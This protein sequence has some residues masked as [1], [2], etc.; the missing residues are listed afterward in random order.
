[1]ISAVMICVWYSIDQPI[2]QSIHRSVHCSV[3]CPVHCLVHCSIRF[4]VPC[5][6]SAFLAVNDAVRLDRFV[7]G[8]WIAVGFSDTQVLAELHRDWWW[9]D[10][11]AR[12]IGWGGVQRHHIYFFADVYFLDFLEA[13]SLLH[14]QQQ[15]QVKISYF[16]VLQDYIRLSQSPSNVFMSFELLD[17]FIL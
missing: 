7:K 2:V 12:G 11:C 17:Y 14:E 13:C 8:L 15:V 4:S 6:S 10:R 9:V 16:W 1:M 3:N 5:I